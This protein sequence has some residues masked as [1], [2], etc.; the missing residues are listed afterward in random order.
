MRHPFTGAEYDYP[1]PAGGRGFIRP[2]SLVSLWSTAPFLQNNTV[3]RFEPQPDVESRM[4][5]F[6]DAIEQMLWPERRPKDALFA[7]ESGPGV[8]IIDRIT[9]D[10]YLDVAEGYIPDYLMP[11]VGAARK[12]FPFVTGTSYSIHVGP[13]PKGMPIGLI[14]N[15]DMLGGELPPEQRDEHRRKIL[16][17]IRRT[18]EE[19]KSHDDLPTI[20]GNLSDDMLAVSKCKDLVVNKGHYF[21]TSYFAEE[22]GL[23]DDDKRALIGLLKTF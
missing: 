8:G 5:S 1:L 20:L 23:S 14:T 22:P 6:Q 7:N 2:A 18:K 16:T 13:F 21:G 19:L 12:L 4:R 10:S 3:G 17:L 11:L 15:M 9:V